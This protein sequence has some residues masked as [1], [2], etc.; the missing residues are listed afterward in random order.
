MRK[1]NPP[2]IRGVIKLLLLLLV[3]VSALNFIALGQLNVTAVTSEK[4]K[5][6]GDFVSLVFSVSNESGEEKEVEF[7][8]GVPDGW[9]PMGTPSTRTISSGERDTIFVTV[10]IP[11]TAKAGDYSIDLGASYNQDTFT[12][13]ANVVVAEIKGVSITTPREKSTARNTSL[14]YSFTVKNTGNVTDTF[15]IEADSGHDWVS[16]VSP[17][18]LHLFP[19]SSKEVEVVLSVPEDAEPGRDSLRVTVISE[20]DDDISGETL[21]FTRVL[22]P[23]PQAVEGELY[24]ILPARI[25]GNFDRSPSGQEQSGR[26]NLIADGELGRGSLYFNFGLS[27]LYSESGVEFKDLDYEE[28]NYEVHLGNVGTVFSEFLSMYGRGIHLE[29][30][31]GNFG[32]SLID[33]SE[34]FTTSGGSLSYEREGVYL[35]ANLVSRKTVDDEIDFT[36]SFLGRFTEYEG[37]ELEIEAGY[38]PSGGKYGGAYRAYAEASIE[39][40]RLEGETFFIGPRF[41]GSSSGNKGFRLSESSTGEAYRQN[42]DYSHYYRTLTDVQTK[43]TLLTD[44]L[45]GDLTLDLL[46]AANMQSGAGTERQFRLFGS[47]SFTNRR[48][49][50]PVPTLDENRQVFRG[51]VFYSFENIEFSL[52]AVEILRTNNLSEETYES[53]SLDQEFGFTYEGIEFAAGF[54]SNMTQNLTTDKSVSTSGKS[55]F[56]LATTGAPYLSFSVTNKEGSLDFEATSTLNPTKD[57]EFSLSADTAIREN[58]V[59]LTGSLD[60]TYEYDL[61]LKFIITKGRVDGYV[62]VDENN[63]G[64]KGESEEG[65]TG[66]VL[67]IENTKVA[68]GENG[69]FKFPTFIPGTY[70]LDIEKLPSKY[71]METELPKQVEI[72]KGQTSYVEIPV[73]ELSEVKV[74]VYEDVNQDGERKA[75]E[76]GIGGV[77]VTLKGEG[78]EKR[79]FTK[80]NGE[81]NFRGLTPGSYALVI[82]QET[83]PPRSEITTENAEIEFSL[84]G[85]E[86]REVE[87]G[88]YQRPKKIIFG[89]PPEADFGY[90]PETPAIGAIVSFSGGLSVDADGKITKYEWDFQGDGEVDETGKIVSHRYEEPGS[91]DVTLRVTD[92][93]GNT[94]SVTKAI[95]VV[96][97]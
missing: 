21:V 92:D 68:T 51:S 8:L 83:L 35:S 1:L 55:Y 94:A 28:D 93:D 88:S 2:T 56:E 46:R 39:P 22:P 29:L 64:V 69:Y 9:A 82:D 45:Y 33:L 66:L 77:G 75:G 90:I 15:V 71:G 80:S 37:G 89:K 70:E 38:T 97:E 74:M 86:T 3:T 58:G 43:S 73:T 47:V 44:R 48:D 41:G 61:P 52:G 63:D 12:G 72:Q 16:E 5:N 91:Y 34:D 19:G 53:F 17:E 49:T 23:S 32:L 25:E 78:V 67:S 57:L 42:I 4:E 14:S 30:S 27:D 59:S 95:E 84:A 13:T 79:S 7:E 62:F 11:S 85:G 20:R 65:V 76:E 31:E 50:E 40:L 6:P 18:S 96:E 81:V 26:L 10:Q 60:F 87:V 24:A 54:S 36:E